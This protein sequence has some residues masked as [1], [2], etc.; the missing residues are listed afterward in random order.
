MKRWLGVSFFL[1]L[2]GCQPAEKKLPDA[3][4]HMHHSSFDELVKRFE[5]P[6]R[7]KWQQPQK[8]AEYMN[9]G[10]DQVVADIGAGTGYLSFPIAQRAK[11]VIAIDIDQRFLDY[12]NEH[13]D[14]QL[15]VETR[16]SEQDDPLLAA[17]EVDKALMVNVAHH[18][19]KRGK[20][21]NKVRNGLKLG[22]EFY[23]VDFKVGDLPVGPPA[24]YKLTANEI[25][26]NLALAGFL[27]IEVDSNALQYQYI[28]KAY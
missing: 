8:L 5:D 14:Q 19:D 9:L 21:F 1:V 15:N 27:N 10:A 6:K 2:L 23:I 26:R 22:G 16:L 17:H 24:K 28:F 25:R 7:A 13:N 4:A 11:K 12:I 3:N 18:L 20:Y